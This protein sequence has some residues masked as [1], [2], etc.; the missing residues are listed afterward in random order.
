MKDLTIWKDEQFRQ[1]RADLDRLFRDFLGDFAESRVVRPD[2]EAE[3]P[4]VELSE[5]NEAVLIRMAFPGLDP[6][7]LSI[8]VSP[9]AVIIT[10]DRQEKLSSEAGAV[11]HRFSQRITL[12]CR[13]EPERAEAL[14]FDHRLEIRLPKSHSATF[15]NITL[16]RVKR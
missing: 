9:E 10:A 11:H 6:A 13:V 12:P 5:E 2:G 1:M 15:R 14:C 3:L 8:E 7:D 16:R 4:R